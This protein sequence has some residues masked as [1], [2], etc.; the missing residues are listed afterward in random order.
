MLLITDI[1]DEDE[2]D[3]DDAFHSS[4]SSSNRFNSSADRSYSPLQQSKHR[5]FSP[6]Q[7][8]H[9]SKSPVNS[10]LNQS[11]SPLQS[12]NR[13]FSPV[14]SHN[15]S[16]PVERPERPRRDYSSPLHRKDQETVSPKLET[17]SPVQVEETKVRRQVSP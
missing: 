10:S 12:Q 1:W 8:H 14:Q 15:Q 11:A 9:R 2:D 4:N 16:T 3:D 13:S 6:V 17:P 7:L 5:S